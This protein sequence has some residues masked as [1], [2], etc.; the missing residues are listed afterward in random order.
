MIHTDGLDVSIQDYERNASLEE[1]PTTSSGARRSECYVESAPGQRFAVHVEVKKNFD[2]KGATNVRIKVKI[3]RGQMTSFQQLDKPSA[4]R[5][6]KVS[7]NAFRQ[8]F[9]GERIKAGARF[10]YLNIGE[11]K[12]SSS[13][14]NLASSFYPFTTPNTVCK[15]CNSV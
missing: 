8:Q 12:I 11:L 7:I 5:S 14:M 3:D 6:N 1:Y 2:Y 9:E 13:L 15:D 4:L 10:Q